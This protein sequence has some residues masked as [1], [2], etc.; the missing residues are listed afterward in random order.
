MTL[1]EL[2]VCF[3]FF[4]IPNLFCAFQFLLYDRYRRNLFMEFPNTLKHTAFCYIKFRQ[5]T[6]ELHSVLC[7]NGSYSCGHH[8]YKS[9]VLG[10]LIHKCL[11]S[12]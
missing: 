6:R 9:H 5:R 8:G 2:S 12:G 10:L 11:N 1:I 3:T 4:N 7:T